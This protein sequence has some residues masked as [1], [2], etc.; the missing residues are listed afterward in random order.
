MDQKELVMAIIT[1]IAQGLQEFV[2][3]RQ[4]GNSEDPEESI[5]S[6]SYIQVNNLLIATAQKFG[7]DPTKRKDTEPD[8]ESNV[9]LD[10]VD[11]KENNK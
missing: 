5:V 7:V 1:E 11:S 9:V 6:A 2:Y 3:N 10:E 8:T 4:E